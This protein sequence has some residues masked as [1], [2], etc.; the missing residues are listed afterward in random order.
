MLESSRTMKVNRWIT[1]TGLLVGCVLL[2]ALIRWLRTESFLGIGVC[3]AGFTFFTDLKG[4]SF[5][6]NGTVRDK[7]CTA[8]RPHTLCGLSPNLLDPKTNRRLPTCTKMMD[9]I[10]NSTSEKYCNSA[11]PNYISPGRVPYGG[12]SVEPA[13]GNGSEFPLGPDRNR[14]ATPFCLVSNK[15][16]I[17]ELA[18]D[19]RK[20]G[21]F[22]CETLKLKE[23]IKCPK[24]LF[25]AQDP[26][27]QG[28]TLYCKS[29]QPYDSKTGNPHFCLP[30]ETLALYPNRRK[31]GKELI[32]MNLAKTICASCSHY[33]KRWIDNDTT[34]K[35]ID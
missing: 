5:C 28:G 2:L 20:S 1:A 30:D 8:T 17:F 27:N 21:M 29:S 26:I 10:A 23:S 22:N 15:K 31:D 16:N 3:P 12:C 18:D 6:C 7:Q 34:A 11:M 14:W 4:A 35:C 25:L 32:G 13:S 19:N 9:T 33:K 24:N